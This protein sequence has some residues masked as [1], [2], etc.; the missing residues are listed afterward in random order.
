MHAHS[1]AHYFLIA[2]SLSS[3]DNVFWFYLLGQIFFREENFV[4]RWQQPIGQVQFEVQKGG[5]F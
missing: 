3:Q 1:L 4:R 5:S 2:T